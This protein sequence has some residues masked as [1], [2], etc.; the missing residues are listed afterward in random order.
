MPA[1]PSCEQVGRSGRDGAGR[2]EGRRVEV[3]SC[4]KEGLGEGEEDVGGVGKEEGRHGQ[5]G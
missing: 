2:E 4:E 5:E 1:T 3:E